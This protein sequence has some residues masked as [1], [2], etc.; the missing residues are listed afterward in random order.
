M[1][2]KMKKHLSGG[3]TGWPAGRFT[4]AP[5]NLGTGFKD[6]SISECAG[7]FRVHDQEKVNV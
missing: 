7:D 6:I 3:V 1:N 4:M 5:G 2:L